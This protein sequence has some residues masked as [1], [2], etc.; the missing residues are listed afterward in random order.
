MTT[1]SKHAAPPRET[2]LEEGLRRYA[3][4]DN[5]VRLALLDFAVAMITARSKSR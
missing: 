5:A 3:P 2:P 4:K 1:Q